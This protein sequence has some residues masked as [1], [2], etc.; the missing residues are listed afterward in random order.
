MSNLNE[1][2]RNRRLLVSVI[3]SL[4]VALM[5]SKPQASVVGLSLVKSG[6]VDA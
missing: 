3:G 1:Y 2:N 4:G 6:S 5:S